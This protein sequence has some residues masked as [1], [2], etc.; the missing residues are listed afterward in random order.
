MKKYLRHLRIQLLISRLCSPVCIIFYFLAWR[1]AVSLCRYGSVRKN[2][3]VLLVSAAFLAGCLIWYLLSCIQYQS[4]AQPKAVFSSA[5]LD[6]GDIVLKGREEGGEEVSYRFALGDVKKTSRTKRYLFFYLRGQ[7]FVVLDKKQMAEYDLEYLQLKISAIPPFR[8][9]NYQYAGLALILAVTLWGGTGVIRAGAG[10]N[11]RLGWFLLDMKQKRAVE[12]AD[13]NLYTGRLDSIFEALDAKL[14]FPEYL[15]ISS[16]FQM[17][18]APDGVIESFDTLLTGF[19]E[20]FKPVNGYLVTYNRKKSSRITVYVQNP[21]DHVYEREKDF[22]TLVDACRVIPFQQNAEDWDG[23]TKFGL[24][25]YGTRSWG[26]STEGIRYIDKQGRVELP[27][28]ALEEIEGP[29]VSV[30][31]PGKEDTI[32]PFRYLYCEDVLGQ[33]NVTG[34]QER[35]MQDIYAESFP[36]Y[37]EEEAARDRIKNCQLAYLPP[38]WLTTDISPGIYGDAE[39]VRDSYACPHGVE[40][41]SISHMDYQLYGESEG[42]HRIN[43]YLEQDRLE[44]LSEPVKQGQEI[45]SWNRSP[46]ICTEMELPNGA[47]RD[48]SASYFVNRIVFISDSRI[49]LRINK[50]KSGNGTQEDESEFMLFDLASGQRLFL[51]DVVGKTKAELK[52]MINSAFSTDHGFYEFPD[53]RTAGD[54]WLENSDESSFYLTEDGVCLLFGRDAFPDQQVMI[55]WDVEVFLPFK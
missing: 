38:L 15:M 37:E 10:L 45:V 9:I 12:L 1:A 8:K 50:T 22:I 14:D 31:V 51:K 46:C 32:T 36:D 29:S 30:Y 7:R 52:T 25:Y 19:D 40:L 54:I 44:F 26:Y 53:G 47:H 18:F 55:F 48:Q 49:Q 20:H 6:D 34:E 42:V 3:T 13:D 11:G 4:G 28:Q 5:A 21:P 24:L 23:E 2:M 39:Q 35:R 33:A 27:A 41:Y 17:Y 16:S 43:E